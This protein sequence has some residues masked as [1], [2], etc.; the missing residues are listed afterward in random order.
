MRQGSEEHLK[1]LKKAS[2]AKWLFLVSVFASGVTSIPVQYLEPSEKPPLY[3][4]LLM[5]IGVCFLIYALLLER[6]E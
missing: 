6:R 3:P 4:F 5:V 2:V 1:I